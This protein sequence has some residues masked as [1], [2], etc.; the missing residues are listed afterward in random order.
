MYKLEIYT[1]PPIFILFIPVLILPSLFSYMWPII[2]TITAL[3]SAMR[4]I[5]YIR[6]RRDGQD[7][8]DS[9]PSSSSSTTPKTTSQ[10]KEKEMA[11]T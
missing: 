9:A 3:A 2:Y 10:E 7:L 11:S 6:L 4:P 5:N 8:S 1:S